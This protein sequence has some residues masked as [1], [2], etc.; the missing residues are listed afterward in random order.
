MY[1]IALISCVSWFKIPAGGGTILLLLLSFFCP[2]FKYRGRIPRQQ[3]ELFGCLRY[4]ASCTLAN[5]QRRFRRNRWRIASSSIC[6][7]SLRSPTPPL[8]L[9]Y[10]F[11]LEYVLEYVGSFLGG[12]VSVKRS[13]TFLTL[14]A[15][16]SFIIVGTRPHSHHRLPHLLSSPKCTVSRL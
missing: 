16:C 15:G 1:G 5:R 14:P 2:D 6:T 3:F 8:S 7:F 4:I 11:N 13:N 10:Q 9:S 12:A